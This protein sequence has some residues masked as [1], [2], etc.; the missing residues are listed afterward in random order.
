MCCARRGRSGA[1]RGCG[2]GP[3][4]RGPTAE[5]R[6]GLDRVRCSRRAERR[7]LSV[8]RSRVPAIFSWGLGISEC[9][10][11]GVLDYRSI[12]LLGSSCVAVVRVRWHGLVGVAVLRWFGPAQARFGAWTRRAGP[13]GRAREMHAGSRA[14][15]M[16][17]PVGRGAA[18][19]CPEA[20]D[21]C[22]LL[23][24]AACYTLGVKF[25]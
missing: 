5:Q 18:G 15:C 20:E 11:T 19:R 14:G 2:M 22:P 4:P 8:I 7:A 6:A 25:G 9:W 17:G 10:D 3:R 12:G 21:R 24:S 23:Y 1:G 13:D 16:R